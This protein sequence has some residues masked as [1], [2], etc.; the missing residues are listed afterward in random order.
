MLPS[1]APLEGPPPCP[2]T[3][4]SGPPSVLPRGPRPPGRG[5]QEQ[6]GSQELLRFCVHFKKKLSEPLHVLAPG[7]HL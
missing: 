3:G 1:T 6:L 4:T 5:H 7:P 2:G